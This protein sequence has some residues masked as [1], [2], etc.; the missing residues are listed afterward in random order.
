MNKLIGSMKLIKSRAHRRIEKLGSKFRWRRDREI[1]DLDDEISTHEQKHLKARRDKSLWGDAA[2]LKRFL[3]SCVGKPWNEVW[4]RLCD[5]PQIINDTRVRD[6]AR[7]YV[8]TPE[9]PAFVHRDYFVDENGLLQKAEWPQYRKREVPIRMVEIEGKQYF[10]NSNPDQLAKPDGF[11]YEVTLEPHRECTAKMLKSFGVETQIGPCVRHDVFS[12]CLHHL[13][14]QLYGAAVICTFKRSVNKRELRAI[15][16]R[17]R[18]LRG[19]EEA[20]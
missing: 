15:E 20:A 13:N 14:Y 4:E 1:E 18:E 11:W 19:E 7:W 5:D 9:T 16:K 2:G 8:S 3:A 17:I 10:H 12:G 6:R